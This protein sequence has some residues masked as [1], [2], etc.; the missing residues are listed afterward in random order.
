[1]KPSSRGNSLYYA[2]LTAV[3]QSG[4]QTDGNVKGLRRL[5]HGRVARMVK[6]HAA[7]GAIDQ[8]AL[9]LQLPHAALQ[10]GGCLF[11]LL[12]WEIGEAGETVR[13]RLYN[14]SK[15]VVRI[16]RQRYGIGRVQSVHAH[17]HQR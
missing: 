13:V 8:S 14:G 16:V 1:M 10:F 2:C 4:V 17:A 5:E 11:G 12:Q 3:G 9:E 6:K 7:C 15:L